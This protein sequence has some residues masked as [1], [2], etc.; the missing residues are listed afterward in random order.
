MIDTS[1]VFLTMGASLLHDDFL[2]ETK[3]ARELYHDYAEPLPIIDYHCHVPAQ[4]IAENRTFQNLTQ[5]WLVGDHYKWRAM[6]ACGVDERWITGDAT[7]WEK[8]EKWA[9]TFPKTL[10]NPLYHWTCLELKHPFG[11]ADRFLDPSTA[12]GIWDE[13]EAKLRLPEFSTRGIQRQMNVEVVCTTDD[14]VDDLKYH[15]MVKADTSTHVKLYPTFRPDNAFAIEDPAEYRR[16]LDRLSGATGRSIG[17]FDDLVEGLRR[18]HEYFHEA[19][20]RLSDHGL[21]SIYVEEYTGGEVNAVFRDMLS[22]K[23]VSQ[24][25]A[26]KFKSALLYELAVMNAGKGWVQQFH[27]G[28][29][30]NVNSRMHRLLGPATGFDAIGDFEMARPLGEFLD[31]L[32][33]DDRLAKTIL[34]NSDPRDNEVFASIA[35]SFQRDTPGKIQYGAAWWFLDHLD[36]ITRQ[37]E[38]LSALGLLSQFVG[39]V[40]DSRSLPSY[41]RHEYFRRILCNMLGSDMTR[42]RL[43]DDLSLVGSMVGDICYFNAKRYF[44]FPDFD[45]SD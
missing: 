31:R 26:L 13:C 39:M 1:D 9:R 32:D 17:S 8:F 27:I 15:R 22:G 33:R 35:G 7:D 2:L 44:E 12:K 24:A 30:R 20:C 36:G 23:P 37:L 16:Y 34:Y 21:D 10:R 40:T 25:E 3:R 14:P 42:G 38:V 11:I 6:R 43:P 18:R 19:G 28:A 29:F 5:I 45:G 4:E 41:S